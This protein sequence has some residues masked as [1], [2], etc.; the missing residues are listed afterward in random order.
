M[1]QPRPALG[2]DVLMAPTP[3]CI[4]FSLFDAIAVSDASPSM[5]RPFSFTVNP[6]LQEK[7]G[8]AETRKP[9]GSSP[10]LLS[11]GDL[12]SKQRD[13][14]WAKCGMG[15]P[16]HPHIPL[17]PQPGASTGEPLPLRWQ[18]SHLPGVKEWHCPLAGVW[19]SQK[20]SPCASPCATL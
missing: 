18:L 2:S 14:L 20:A 16:V 8:F 17:K 13:G 15:Q 11:L 5:P 7:A 12:S 10:E 1:A 3:Q 6:K 4:F 19:T 9:S